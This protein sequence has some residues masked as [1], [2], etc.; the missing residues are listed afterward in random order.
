VAQP[1]RTEPP[2]GGRPE[3]TPLFPDDAPPWPATEIIECLWQ[4][5]YPEPGENWDV[6][7]DLDGAHPP[8]ESVGCYIHWPIVDGPAPDTATLVA[9]ADLVRDLRRARKRVLV[10]CAA[11][12][13][14]S[15]LLAAASLIRDGVDPD[16]AIDT[17]RGRRAGAL[18]NPWFVALLRNSFPATGPA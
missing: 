16:E 18:N 9:L 3:R 2:A 12:M 8:I 13:N 7:I 6:V 14:R 1:D 17:I 5:G 11:G 4:S 15:G 10:H